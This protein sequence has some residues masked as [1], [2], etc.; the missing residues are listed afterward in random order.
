[1]TTP[2]EK[3]IAFLQNIGITCRPSPGVKGFLPHCRIDH[4]TIVFDPDLAPGAD[5]LHEAGHLAI[6][7]AETRHHASDNLREWEKIGAARMSA[8]VDA[9][10]HPDDPLMCA[11]MQTSDPEATAWAFAAGKA[12][13]LDDED[14]IRDDECDGEG[15]S[16]RF[17]LQHC[18][19]IGI[20]PVRQ[21]IDF[22]G[23]I[24]V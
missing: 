8:M 3:V 12:A 15:A 21:S 22:Y 24:E 18:A 1:M 6:I 10:T 11:Y 19:Y 7:P 9:G 4:G 14:I 13:G 23:F 5:V 17:G 20:H 16:I 2:L